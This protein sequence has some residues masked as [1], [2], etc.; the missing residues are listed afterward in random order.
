MRK[1]HGRGFARDENALQR[2]L[3][4]LGPDAADLSAT[5]L[6]SRLSGLRRQIKPALVDQSVIAGLGNLLADEIL[7]RATFTGADH[8]PICTA[9]TSP[10]STPGCAPSYG[11]PSSKAACHRARDSKARF[12]SAEPWLCSPSPIVTLISTGT[13]FKNRMRCASH[14]GLSVGSGVTEYGSASRNAST[15]CCSESKC[16]PDGAVTEQERLSAS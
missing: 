13:G 14:P 11:S 10:A 5:E 6:R 16:V 9:R 2:E 1:L 3:D 12:S 7:W 15:C 8:A 4:Q